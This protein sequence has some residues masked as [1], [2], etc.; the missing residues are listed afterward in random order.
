VPGFDEREG[1][2]ELYVANAD[3]TDAHRVTHTPKLE[4][5]APSWDPSGARI[6]YLRSP[7]GMFGLL[8]GKV[9][10][11][12]A[13]GSCPLAI[14]TQ[15]PRR[16]GGRLWFGEPSWQPGPGRGAGPISC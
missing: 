2:S 5:S 11:S 6:A 12:N 8:K 3:G 16:K 1:T 13:D 4:E 10:E 9:V 14:P 7:G 15:R